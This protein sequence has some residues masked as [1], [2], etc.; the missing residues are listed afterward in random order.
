MRPP[1][2]PT[3]AVLG[4]FNHG[5]TTLI[6]AL[7]GGRAAAAEPGR[8]TQGVRA[9]TADFADGQVRDRQ[10]FAKRAPKHREHFPHGVCRIPFMY[11]VV[12]PRPKF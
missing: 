7:T 10:N 3:V 9:T 5:K 12:L 8:I 6:D 2:V 11:Y 4:H 1:Q